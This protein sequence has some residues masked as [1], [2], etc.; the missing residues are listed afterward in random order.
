LLKAI[1]IKMQIKIKVAPKEWELKRFLSSKCSEWVVD[2]VKRRRRLFTIQRLLGRSSKIKKV[3]IQ[4]ENM[5]FEA[6]G[7]KLENRLVIMFI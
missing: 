6:Q 4:L 2:L 5:R 3:L 7:S 1:N